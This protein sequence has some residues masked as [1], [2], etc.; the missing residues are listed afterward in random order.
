MLIRRVRS[1]LQG[2]LLSILLTGSVYDGSH[3][4]GSDVD[5][6]VLWSRPYSLRRR[7]LIE[8]I[9]IDLFYD[10]P[11]GARRMIQRAHRRFFVWMYAHSVAP[12]DPSLV[13]GRLREEGEAAWK[14][15]RS[16]A[17][18]REE[19]QT[20]CEMR[21]GLRT[22]ER[23]DADDPV[24]FAYLVGPYVETVVE[25]YWSRHGRWGTH[26]KGAL[27]EIKRNDPEV[28][29]LVAK[30]HDTSIGVNARKRAVRC[31]AELVMGS[32]F[33]I[34]EVEGTPFRR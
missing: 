17:S 21:D 18:K 31:L 10:D 30:I 13:G 22:I 5:V 23:A 34:K 3:G 25:A 14:R 4:D 26:R 19:F 24:N 2:D 15:G 32:D 20:H 27:R 16:R 29:S 7:I 6:C 11:D 1:E 33:E 12:Y 9:E 28:Y 8:D